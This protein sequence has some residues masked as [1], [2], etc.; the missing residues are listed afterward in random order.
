MES[1]LS[2]LSRAG[3]LDLVSGDGSEGLLVSCGTTNCLGVD[4]VLGLEVSLSRLL[5][6]RLSRV[7]EGLVKTA[8]YT[9]LARHRGSDKEPKRQDA[10]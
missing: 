6:I 10:G 4:C 9:R 7:L 8:V 1:H 2:R 5:G 3:L